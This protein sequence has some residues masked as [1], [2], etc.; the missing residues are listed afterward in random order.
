[1]TD[2]H[3]LAKYDYS[4]QGADELSIK[5]NERLVLLDDSKAWWK[6][7][8]NANQAGFVP[9]N[10][11]KKTKPSLLTSLR[12][13]LGRRKGTEVRARI[14]ITKNG[15]YSDSDIPQGGDGVLENY[16]AVVVKYPYVAQQDDEV[17]LARGDRVTVVEKSSDGW[18][19]G[20]KE[21]SGETGWFPSNYVLD[22]DAL[23]ASMYAHPADESSNG[24]DVT[25]MVVALYP[26]TSSNSEELGFEKGEILQ[27]VEKLSRDPEWCRAK[28]QRGLTG[29][30]P[31][32]YV[33][34]L[35]MDSGF[36]QPTPESQSNNSLSGQ[37]HSI[38]NSRSPSGGIRHRYKLSGPYADKDWFYGNITRQE[39]EDLLDQYGSDG[40]FLIRES[41]TNVSLVIY[42]I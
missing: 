13:T 2:V 19:R 22:E 31:R 41:E 38:S 27:V 42:F 29:L 17:T 5:K 4:A 32:N 34:S 16:K 28:N 9:S 11:V 30:V 18:W 12:N 1:M 25:E 6:V 20:R 39:C 7:Q 14:T 40:D 24:D 35:S 23:D 26:F 15:S 3:V 8:N 10:Y 21:P 37:S 33:Q 36:Q